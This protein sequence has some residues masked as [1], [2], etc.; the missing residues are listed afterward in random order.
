MKMVVN[1]I[2]AHLIKILIV[3]FLSGASCPC[4]G[5]GIFA[6]TNS[7]SIL[8]LIGMVLLGM[9]Y[10]LFVKIKEIKKLFYGL[11]G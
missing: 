5:A 7:M 1:F 2:R 6:C 10:L 9:K 8:G 11:I 4:C 3:L